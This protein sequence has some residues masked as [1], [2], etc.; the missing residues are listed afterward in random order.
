MLLAC[1]WNTIK[2]RRSLHRQD[3]VLEVMLRAPNNFIAIDPVTKKLIK[4]NLNIYT[5]PAYYFDRKVDEV[6]YVTWESDRMFDYNVA[7]HLHENSPRGFDFYTGIICSFVIIL[8]GIAVFA[9]IIHTAR[10][11][12]VH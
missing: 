4:K 11:I 10:S 1:Q 3:G 7:Y 12:S 5:S 6:Q 9:G 2:G 8:L